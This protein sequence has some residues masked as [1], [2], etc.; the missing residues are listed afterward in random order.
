MKD[1][2]Y[3]RNYYQT[4]KAC[5]LERHKKFEKDKYD[6]DPIHREKVK[7]KSKNRYQPKVKIAKTVESIVIPKPVILPKEMV[8]T[9]RKLRQER[10]VVKRSNSSQILLKILEVHNEQKT[11]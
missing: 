7:R 6:Q 5:I 8:K 3:Y 10:V 11:A 9:K 1:N 4:N 2:V